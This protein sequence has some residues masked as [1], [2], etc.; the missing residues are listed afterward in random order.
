[1]I[2][3]EMGS[4][5]ASRIFTICLPLHNSHKIQPLIQLSW[6]PQ[7]HSIAKKFKNHSVQTQGDSSPSA[8]LANSSE[9]TSKLQK[10]RQRQMAVRGQAF[11][12]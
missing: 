7:K 2:S 6:G 3:K 12:L 8:K 11:P 5:K 1:M 4:Y 9:N 10:A